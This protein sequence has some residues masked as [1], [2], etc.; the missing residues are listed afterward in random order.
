MPKEKRVY[1]EL[2][3]EAEQLSAH[4]FKYFQDRVLTVDTVEDYIVLPLRQERVDARGAKF[5]GGI[6]DEKMKFYAPSA[7]VHDLNGEQGSLKEGYAVDLSTVV[8]DERTVIWGGVLFDHFGHFLCE[9]LNR[10]WY[11]AQYP[12][13][14]YPVVFI[15]E[16]ARKISSSVRS[17]LELLG[18]SD[19]R[20]ILIDRPTRFARIIVPEQS[21]VLTGFYTKEFVLPYRAMAAGI[22]AK[23]FEK[24]YFSRRKFKGGIKIFGEDRLEKVFKANGYHVVYPERIDLKEQIAYVK[25][26]KEIVCVMGSAAHLTLFAAPKTKLIV[27]ERTEHINKEQILIN[28]A[29]ELDWFSIGAN[30]NYLPVGHEFSPILMGIT[31]QVAAFFADHGFKFDPKDV[32]RI[33]DRYVR[34]FNQAWLSR[35]SSYKH[36]GQLEQIPP[37][38]VHRLRLYCQTAFLSLRQR[39]FMK[40]TEGEWR[41]WS[42]LGFSFKTKR[43]R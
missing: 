38:Y 43:R 13:K 2:S 18:I 26:A 35:Y 41:V 8:S 24:V 42:I 31:D 1:A 19:D 29:M 27:L 20:L 9:S 16:K 10:L 14:K 25:G 37:V 30:M 32:N 40:R 12:E 23:P 15:C 34:R 3:L 22:E 33:S 7:H 4:G 17:L 11:A 28:Q 36:N 5:S 6:I 21:S 39:L